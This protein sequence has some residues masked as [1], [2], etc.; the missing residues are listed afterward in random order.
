MTPGWFLQLPWPQVL[1][2]GTMDRR[3]FLF[4]RAALAPDGPSGKAAGA[5]MWVGVAKAGYS[6]A[7]ELPVFAIL[8]LLPTALA[9]VLEWKVL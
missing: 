5:N 3:R 8:F 1:M 4:S 2:R 6:V 7:E 9:I